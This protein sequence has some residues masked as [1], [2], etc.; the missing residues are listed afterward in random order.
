M[1]KIYEG[2][3]QFTEVMEPIKLSIHQYLLLTEEPV[4][5][6]TG[7]IRQAETVVPLLKELLGGCSLKYILTS[8]F[9]ADECG[10]ISVLLK[11]YPEAI[12]ICSELSLRQFYGFGLAYKLEVKK[13][14]DILKGKDYEF[15]FIDYPS[16]IH[17]ENGIVFFEKK[18]G[19]FFSSDLMFRMG[20][21]HGQVIEGNWES[22]IASSGADRLPNQ[23]LQ[24]KLT[25]DLKA[26]NPKFIATGH[27]PCVKL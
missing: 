12:T 14:G 13:P 10:G 16:E 1:T 18:R 4:L 26:I 27:G 20:E 21:S 9:E 23:E 6:Q 24:E 25:N 3:Y 2:L 11:E 8:H 22:E 17:N 7:T 19:I 15:E 5:I